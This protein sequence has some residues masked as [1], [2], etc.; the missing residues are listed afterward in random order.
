MTAI[1][2]MT[3]HKVTVNGIGMYYAAA[4]DGP[5]VYLLHGYPQTHYAWRKQVPVLAEQYTV[6]TPDLRGYGLSDKPATGY[7]KRTM[8][9]DIVALM[10]HLGHDRIVLVGHDRGARVGTR[11]AKDHPDRID[12]LV[13]M[14]NIPT[15]V[16]ADTYD[17]A[18]AR[19]GYW[20]FTFLTVPDLPETLI[21]GREREWLTHFYTSWAYDPSFLSADE[22]EVYVQAYQ[23]P[24]AVRGSCEDYRAG[25]VDVAQDREDAD[26]LISCPVLAMWGQDFAAVGKAYDVAQVWRGMASDLR[27]VALPD[28]GHLCP[29]ERPDLV[30]AA[31]LDFLADWH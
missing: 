7:D 3:G 26:Q 29:E 22:L 16:V 20:F 17:L 10:D 1:P 8:A 5:P 12:R 18:K 2:G 11:F 31:L 27:T 30:N 19:A 28:C 4:G 13:V 21:T 25:A 14:D 24:G 9:A 6:V 23:A 15:R